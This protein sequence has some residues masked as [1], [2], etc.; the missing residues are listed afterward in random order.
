MGLDDMGWN[1]FFLLD[2]VLEGWRVKEVC[3]FFTDLVFFQ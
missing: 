3:A 2:L 1:V